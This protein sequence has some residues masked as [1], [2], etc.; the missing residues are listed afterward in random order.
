M[1]RSNLFLLLPLVLVPLA[2]R[3]SELLFPCVDLDRLLL[4]GVF[5]YLAAFAARPLAAT[6]FGDWLGCWTGV[7]GGDRG[8]LNSPRLI[9]YPPLLPVAPSG[10]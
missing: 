2:L 1:A 3:L 6:S 5:R 4:V 9:L 10:F 8:L 7:A